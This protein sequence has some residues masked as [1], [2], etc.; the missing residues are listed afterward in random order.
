MPFLKKAKTI[1]I[2]VLMLAFISV[3]FGFFSLFFGPKEGRMES[4]QQNKS[5]NMEKT[6]YQFTLNDINGS[7]VSLSSYKGKVVII[8]N[9]ASKC[10]LTPQ[11]K[12]LQAFYESYKDKGVVVLGFPANNFM[13][14]EPGTDSEIKSFCEKNYGVTFPV[15][16]KISVKGSDMAPLYRFLTSKELNG[17][18]DSGVKWNFQKY[19]ID[20]EGRLVTFFD[21]RTEI[22]DEQ[23]VKAIEALL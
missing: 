3:M 17:V 20:R 19:L 16:S 5:Q 2:I 22:N 21:P 14:Q 23:V 15:F 13:G 7:P 11:Y 4:Y 1:L 6:I 18:M 10:G 8:V 12:E 9:V